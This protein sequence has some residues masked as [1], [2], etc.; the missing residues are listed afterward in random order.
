MIA[1]IEW[2]DYGIPKLNSKKLVAIPVLRYL[3]KLLTKK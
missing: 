3:S 2:L 1:Y